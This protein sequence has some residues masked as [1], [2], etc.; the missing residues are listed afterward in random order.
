M[1]VCFKVP[2][3][4]E[5]SFQASRDLRN[6][7]IL[8]SVVAIFSVLFMHKHS[9]YDIRG[10]VVLPKQSF[11]VRLLNAIFCSLSP[12]FPTPPFFLI[13]L[14]RTVSNACVTPRC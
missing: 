3:T 2:S 11:A 9:S 1:S 7:T 14:V 8:N 5:Q 12:K 13:H 4:V 10:A 6:R